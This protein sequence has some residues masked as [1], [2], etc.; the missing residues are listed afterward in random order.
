MIFKLY[1]SDTGDYFDVDAIDVELSDWFVDQCRDKHFT[2]DIF[3]ENGKNPVVDKIIAVIDDNI[4]LIN[5]ALS[6][7]R[8]PKL[9]APVNYFD[10]QQLNQCHKDWIKLLHTYPAVEK[11]LYKVDQT[12][13]DR[14]HAINRQIHILESSFRYHVYGVDLWR[15][16]NPFYGKAFPTGE[17]SLNI[18]Y[19]DHGRSSFEK[20]INFDSNPNDDELNQ[21][22][23]IGASVEIQLGKTYTHNLPNEY[24]EYCQINNLPVGGCKLPLGNLTDITTNLT[25]AREIMNKNI[26][27]ENNFL[28]FSK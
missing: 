28:M 17:F 19:T 26:Q 21:W 8:L 14:F 25:R 13:F 15:L 3:Q 23:S 16:P 20:W 24:L 1:W 10:Q 22:N 4:K 7:Y 12:L 9:P 27:L 2:S 6:K 18:R 11:L 5:T